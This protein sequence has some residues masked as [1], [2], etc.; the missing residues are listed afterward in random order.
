M[1][2]SILDED[3]AYV[4]RRY[5]DNTPTYFNITNAKITSIGFFGCPLDTTS[6]SD[7]LPESIIECSWIGEEGNVQLKGLNSDVILNNSTISYFYMDSVELIRNN[8]GSDPMFKF[9]ISNSNSK[10]IFNKCRFSSNKCYLDDLESTKMNTNATRYFLF[11]GTIGTFMMRDSKIIHTNNYYDAFQIFNCNKAIIRNIEVYATTNTNHYNGYA[12][13]FIR[14]NDSFVYD[15][16][17]QYASNAHVEKL[18]MKN[19]KMLIRANSGESNIYIPGL[20]NAVSN[21]LLRME[22]IE[23]TNDP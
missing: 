21:S 3:T 7:Q 10:F 23:I 11:S 17:W 14:G 19:V 22:N 2:P 13:G 12:F 16:Y 1:V 4:I 8:G 18:D 9:T 6:I 20:V 5:T 15:D